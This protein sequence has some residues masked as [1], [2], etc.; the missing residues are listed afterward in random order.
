MKILYNIQT[1]TL[2][3]YPFQDDRP[4]IG[5]DPNALQVF[6]L[7]QEDKPQHNSST[8]YL[9]PTQVINTETRQVVQSWEIT[10]LPPPPPPAPITVPS[11]AFFQAIGRDLEITLKAKINETQD[12]NQ[13]H[14]LLKFLEYPY[15]QSNHPM[16]AQF[17]T[18]LGKT[19]AQ[20]EGWFKAA[21]AIAYP[22]G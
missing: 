11:P 18:M 2:Q 8:H 16:V 21:E 22:K 13:R 17:G 10:P 14:Y 7:I 5:L 20:I 19:P 12:I 4:I 6:E 1:Q 15:F 9:R 3:P